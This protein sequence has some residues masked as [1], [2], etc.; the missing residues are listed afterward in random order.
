MD[1]YIISCC[2]AADLSKVHFEE[3]NIRYMAFKFKLD[4]DIYSDDLG[5]SIDID[6][7]YKRMIAGATTQTI[8]PK[9]ED[10]YDYFRTFLAE[11]KDVLHLTLSSGISEAYGAAVA[12]QN[13][14]K[15]EFP[16]RKI[17]VVDSLAASSGMGLLVDA[18]A[19]K[20]DEGLGI[21][22]V[23]DW[24]VNNRLSVN[25][26]FFSTTL[27]YYIRGGRISKTA[28]T[29]GNIF[30]IC[31]LMMVNDEG[32]LMIWEVVRIKRKVMKETLK[33]M[34]KLVRNG[35]DYNG[36]CYI[37]NAGCYE[38]A[39]ALADMIEKSFPKLNGKVEIFNIGTTI[40]S[41]SGPGTVAVFFWGEDRGKL[42]LNSD[43]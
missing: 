29:M 26:W 39:R 42:L 24:V 23:R 1:D 35:L 41:H 36:K 4:K 19:D 3:R 22:E 8:H 10:Y 33:K 5:E 9:E 20:R 38:D 14:L 7:F 37:S 34:E 17:Y 12:A 32:K 11:G 2:S 16:E 28:G 31:P 15:E 27:T 25:H 43:I 18:A 30:K 13:R 40:G 21:D 6:E